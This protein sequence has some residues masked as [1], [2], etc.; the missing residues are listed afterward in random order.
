MSG[1]PDQ[2]VL[3]M[4]VQT[5]ASSVVDR[6]AAGQPAGNRV[7]GRCGAAACA[8]ADIQTSGLSIQP[9]YRGSGQAPGRLRRQRAADRD[10]ASPGEA[11]SQ[12]QAA[13][14]AGGN[15]TTVDGV[16]LNLADNSGLLA[17]ARAA[18][19]RDAQAKAAQFAR[20][21]GQPLGGVISV[22]DQSQQTPLPAFAPVASGGRPPRC[23]S[24]PASSR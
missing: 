20:A 11:G 12:I 5:S 1:T 21:L 8:A 3:S 13:V 14:S 7:T 2:L 22:S 10:A 4:G 17:A 18:A 15:A 23:R 9:N 24:R 19:V 16:S 6:A